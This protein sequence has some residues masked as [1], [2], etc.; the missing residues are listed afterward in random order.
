MKVVKIT[1][2]ERRGTV[3]HGDYECNYE[4]YENV[5]YIRSGKAYNM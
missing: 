1:L 3:R 2:T 5:E 4:Q